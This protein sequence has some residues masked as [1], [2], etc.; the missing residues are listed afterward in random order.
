MGEPSRDNDNLVKE[1]VVREINKLINTSSE[2]N[3]VFANDP[4]YKVEV[5]TSHVHPLLVKSPKTYSIVNLTNFDSSPVKQLLAIDAHD[6]TSDF[7][8][9]FSTTTIREEEEP[10]EA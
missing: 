9:S 10:E 6:K 5:Y 1:T 3:R 2:M 7:G 8:Q 4:N